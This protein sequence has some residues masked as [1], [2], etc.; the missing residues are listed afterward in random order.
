MKIVLMGFLNKYIQPILRPFHMLLINAALKQK[1]VRLHMAFFGC[2]ICLKKIVMACKSLHSFSVL[3]GL[4]NREE[5]LLV[6]SCLSV[7]PS[8]LVEQL[9][10][11][12]TNCHEILYFN[13]FR[14]SAEKIKVSL[15]SENNSGYSTRRPIH[16]FHHISL[17]SS[18]NKNVSDK[19][20]RE[21]QNTFYIQ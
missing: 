5:R 9:C 14:K 15:K 2:I 10:S 18:W 11:H 19:I 1:S 7:Y 8:V 13:I 4:Q 16:I 21:N 20:C 17:S 12:S 3:G 6:S